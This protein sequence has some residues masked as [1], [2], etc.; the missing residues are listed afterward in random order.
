MNL[1]SG[2]IELPAFIYN[3]EPSC[4]TVD[5]ELFFPQEIEI[6]NNKVAHKYYNLAAARSICKSCPLQLQC[7]EYALKNH[8]IGVWGGTTESQREELRKNSRPL[9]RRKATPLLW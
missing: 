2:Q 4:S 6:S 8:E 7:L 9:A 5:P 1:G 3:G